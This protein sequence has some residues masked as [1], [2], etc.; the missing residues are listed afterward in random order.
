MSRLS[1]LVLAASLL[2]PALAAANGGVSGWVDEKTEGAVLPG[3]GAPLAAT[4]LAKDEHVECVSELLTI[5][6][7][8]GDAHVTVEYVLRNRGAPKRIEYGFPFAIGEQEVVVEGAAAQVTGPFGKPSDYALIVDGKAVAASWR[9]G[10]ELPREIPVPAIEDNQGLRG[11]LEYAQE[12]LKV[13]SRYRWFYFVSPLDLPAAREVKL[14]VTYS[15]PYLVYRKVK[16]ESGPETSPPSF[17]YL[18]STGGG[19]RGGVIGKLRIVVR[20][21]GGTLPAA[22]IE[23]LPFVRKGEV[24]TF[25]GRNVR[26][27]TAMNLFIRTSEFKRVEMTADSDVPSVIFGGSGAGSPWVSPP[28]GGDAPAALQLSTLGSTYPYDAERSSLRHRLG[29]ATP[30]GTAQPARVRVELGFADGR[31]DVFHATFKQAS[32]HQIGASGGFRYVYF[33]A[34]RQPITLRLEFQEVHPAADGDRRVRLSGIT[35]EKDDT[36]YRALVPG[37]R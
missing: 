5:A 34:A 1:R 10:L 37:G 32:A 25:E 27:T 29:I 16:E 14:T 30:K 23:G 35:L 20:E 28:V 21:E 19:W 13:K 26:P 9:P 12:K 31:L 22:G 18:L 6:L 7:R 33:D 8:Q 3:D 17:S 36:N 2:A 11:R 24:A 4:A 15:S